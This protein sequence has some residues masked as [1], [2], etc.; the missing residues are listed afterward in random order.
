MSVSILRKT[1]S[2]ATVR[3]SLVLAHCLPILTVA[4]LQVDGR[5]LSCPLIFNGIQPRAQ[6]V[7]IFNARALW[8]YRMGGCAS[9]AKIVFF[10]HPM[11]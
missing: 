5:I 3:M 1:Y 2:F 9:V 11:R 7:G 8:R 4:I 10:F 6:H